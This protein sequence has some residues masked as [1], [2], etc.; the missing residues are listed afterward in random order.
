MDTIPLLHESWGAWPL[1][2]PLWIFLWIVVIATVIRFLVLRRDGRGAVP[3]LPRA[4][5]PPRSW[6]NGSPGA[7]STRTS[8]GRGWISF[9]SRLD[10]MTR[11]N[12][13]VVE[14]L[15]REFKKGPRAVDGID[16]YVAPGEIYGFLGPERRRQ[17]D[18]RADADDS[19]PAD[20]R[21]P[22]ASAGTTF[23]RRA[24]RC[25]P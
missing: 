14:Q 13:I 20:R 12:S 21:A 25:A 18:D 15:V 10:W 6:P 8:T 3:G 4:S 11:D 9:D 2:A 1:L 19:A 5:P 17:V 23:A 24:R 16:L 7:R 22:P